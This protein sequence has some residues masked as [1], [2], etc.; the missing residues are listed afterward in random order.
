MATC[1]PSICSRKIA[2]R[3]EFVLR[4]GRLLFSTWTPLV[5]SAEV[6]TII[7][8]AA[9]ADLGNLFTVAYDSGFTVKRVKGQECQESWVGRVGLPVPGGQDPHDWGHECPRRAGWTC[10]R[11]RLALHCSC[12]SCSLSTGKQVRVVL[13]AGARPDDSEK[14]LCVLGSF[15]RQWGKASVRMRREPG[16]PSPMNR[17]LALCRAK[18]TQAVQVETVGLDSEKAEEELQ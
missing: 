12:R 6:Y 8:G 5:L 18:A 15:G 9:L 1:R 7:A 10:P 11:I 14:S 13:T 17:G 2:N 4:A 3:L 16:S